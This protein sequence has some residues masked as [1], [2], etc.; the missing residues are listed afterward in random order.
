M[1]H[2]ADLSDDELRD[3]LGRRVTSRENAQNLQG[4]LV[5]ERDDPSFAEVIDELL[6]R[7]AR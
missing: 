4:I 5:R 1:R 7:P 3:R 6:E 2:W